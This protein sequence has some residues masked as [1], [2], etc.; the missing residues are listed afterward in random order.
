MGGTGHVHG[1]F[2]EALTSI[3]P[4]VEAS[5]AKLRGNGQSVWFTGH[6][7][8]GTLAMLAGAR[9]YPEDS[10]L[11]RQCPPRCRP[12]LRT[13]TSRRCATSTRTA[14]CASRLTRS[15][16]SPAVETAGH[17]RALRAAPSRWPGC[18]SA[19]YPGRRTRS[20]L[21]VCRS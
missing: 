3:W 10:R 1:G 9:M 12:S 2:T 5:R 20:G 8:G 4:H 11:A 7:L 15:G 6:G 13:H 17:E 16:D 21:T 19:P 14:K 18:G